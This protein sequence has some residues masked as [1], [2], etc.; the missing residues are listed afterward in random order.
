MSDWDRRD[1]PAEAPD[2]PPALEPDEPEDSGDYPPA[3][4]GD[5]VI[6]DA[7]AREDDAE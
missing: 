3:P 7:G 2:A 5:E 1:P 4:W 6:G